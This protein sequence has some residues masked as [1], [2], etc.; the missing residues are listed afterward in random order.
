MFWFHAFSLW[1]ITVCAILCQIGFIHQQK[2]K[3]SVVMALSNSSL[4]QSEQ[5]SSGSGGSLIVESPYIVPLS[6]VFGEKNFPHVSHRNFPCVVTIIIPFSLAS[7]GSG[8]GGCPFLSD[9]RKMH[10]LAGGQFHPPDKI[11]QAQGDRDWA[12]PRVAL[13]HT[14]T[15]QPHY[16]FERLP[17]VFH[18]SIR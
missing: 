13:A 10:T 1:R 11:C 4:A 12:L 15:V 2:I 9:H 16:G 5:K 3:P 7:F 8:P 18:H 17:R 14:A 6:P